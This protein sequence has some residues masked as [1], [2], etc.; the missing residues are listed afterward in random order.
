MISFI[1]IIH[2]P[3]YSSCLSWSR[4]RA[5]W[6]CSSVSI[7]NILPRGNS[8]SGDN[9][10]Y[11]HFSLYFKTPISL[12]LWSIRDDLR[13]RRNDSKSSTS[14][15]VK[16]DHFIAGFSSPCLQMQPVTSCSTFREAILMRMSLL[17]AH[18][19]PVLP[20]CHQVSGWPNKKAWEQTS[21]L[22][23][24][25]LFE[26]RRNRQTWDVVHYWTKKQFQHRACLWGEYLRW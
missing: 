23:W 4:G 15:F 12:A 19:L 16:N 10:L 21:D 13:F 2:L 9:R 6:N 18:V 7:E 8:G 3:I 5:I 14:I 17:S 22:I 26:F 1:C 24:P 25:I 20:A 11:C